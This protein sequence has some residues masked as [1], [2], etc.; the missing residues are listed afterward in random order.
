MGQSSPAM[1]YVSPHCILCVGGCGG[2]W[3]EG[4]G[5]IS[6][7]KVSVTTGDDVRITTLYSVCEVGGKRGGQI[8]YENGSVITG[9]DI[10]IIIVCL[11]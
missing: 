1:M 8:N 2:E 9:Y 11:R 4:G 6:H 10:R 5:Q 3:G 7:E